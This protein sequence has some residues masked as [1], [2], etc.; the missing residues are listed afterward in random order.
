MYVYSCFLV[1]NRDNFIIGIIGTPY[2]IGLVNHNTFQQIWVSFMVFIPPGCFRFRIY[3]FYPHQPH[4]ALNPFS[5]Y[6]MALAIQKRRQSSTPIKRGFRVLLIN[7]LHESE[8]IWI[9]RLRFVVQG[10]FRNLK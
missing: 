6:Q 9:Y 1:T 7:Q 4:Q 5:I 2:V 10:S 3:C 8:R